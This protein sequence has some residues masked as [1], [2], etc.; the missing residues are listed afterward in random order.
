MAAHVAGQ[1]DSKSAM[2]HREVVLEI[3][4]DAGTEGRR[5][6][7]AV[8][9]D[10]LARSVLRGG[11]RRASF[12]MHRIGRHGKKTRARCPSTLNLKNALLPWTAMSCGARKHYMTAVSTMLPNAAPQSNGRTG[13]TRNMPA[14]TRLP[15]R[16]RIVASR[17]GTRV[18]TRVD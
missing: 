18:G 10:E 2:A 6:H 16:T 9:Y 11:A 7:L 5:W 12:R 4:T 15:A 17:I 3:A 13:Q 1:L 14:R 8:M